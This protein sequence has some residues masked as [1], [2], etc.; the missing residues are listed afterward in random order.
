MNLI[1]PFEKNLENRFFSEIVVIG[2]QNEIL[3]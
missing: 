3:E 2:Q 1:G